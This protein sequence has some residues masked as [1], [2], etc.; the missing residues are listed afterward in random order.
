MRVLDLCAGAGGLSLGFKNAGLEVHGVEI[1]GDA[2]ETHRAQ[3]GSCDQADLYEYH[4]SGVYDIVGGGVP[5]QDF[6][7]SGHRKGTT[8]P[9]GRLYRESLRIAKE[10][11]ARAWFLENVL[12]ITCRPKGGTRPI[13]EILTEARA[14]GW[15]A[16]YRVLNAADYGVPQCR[17]RTILVAFRDPRDL[18]AFAWPVRTHNE[19]GRRGLAR[20]VT[21]ADALGLNAVGVL[22]KPSHTVSTEG[23]D[24]GGA[25]PFA[26]D[27]YRAQLA[28]ALAQ[29]G[30]ADRPAT[31]VLA[32]E[33]LAPAG[34]HDHVRTEL[35][36][37]LATSGLK[38]RPATT[39]D[40]TNGISPAGNHGR[41]KRAV[42]L[43]PDQLA[44]LQSFPDGFRFC[45]RTTAS[46]HKQIGNAVPPP[47][48]RAV[49]HSI[50]AALLGHA[51][52]YDRDEQLSL[53]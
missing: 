5:C 44:R 1:D 14:Q 24:T 19:H 6:S 46:L 31:T 49:A 32:D 18:A 40:T 13:T 26:N 29:A 27:H 20:W 42:R 25:E 17:Y 41:K 30:L 3:V 16:V 8:T 33:S 28:E 45:A 47:L 7:M 52:V 35:V 48:A 37:P 10:A 22:A 23:A 51:R 11:G 50:R 4:P 43:T 53:L 36:D 34:H 21:V 12:G 15:H 39:V 9:R 2:C 38:N